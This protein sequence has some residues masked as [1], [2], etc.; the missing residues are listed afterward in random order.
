MVVLAEEAK[1]EFGCSFGDLYCGLMESYANTL[2]DLISM[3]AEFALGE[4]RLAE[5]SS[6]LDA[7]GV[8]ASMWLALS[9][10]VMAVT[11]IVS[12]AVGSLLQRPDLMKR[13]LLGTLGAFPATMLG[14]FIVG[15]GLVIADQVADG[16]L[17]RLTGT[18]GFAGMIGA[19]LQTSTDPLDPSRLVAG[20]SPVGSGLIIL[21]VLF[22]G[23]LFLTIAMA[24]R[25]FVIVLLIAFAPLGFVLL[26]SKGGGEWVKRWASAI[27][28]SILAKP[29]MYGALLLVTSGFSALDT[30][31]SFETI[32]L[33]IGFCLVA[34]LPLMAYNFF[35]FMGGATATAGD[36]AAGRLASAGRG[37]GG[38]AQRMW[39]GGV[40]SGGSSRGAA[41]GAAGTPGRSGTP[42]PSNGSSVAPSTAP[43]SQAAGSGAPGGS[44]VRPGAGPGSGGTWGSQ[45]SPPASPPR[46]VPPAPSPAPRSL[47]ATPPP[48]HVPKGPGQ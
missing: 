40:S 11:G 47:S 27:T 7:A 46:P 31:W 41:S 39:R 25:D 6:L 15:E 19:I 3:F 45:P 34:F 13:A 2:H 23:L 43:T 4:N 1:I 29:L 16:L 30:I 21:A 12:L 22:L 44:G 14:F 10:M 32:T 9:L 8:Q 20:A 33:G 26:P 36:Q 18:S 48:A 17:R 38:Q 35:S 5:G 28:A 42:A 37:A 24:F